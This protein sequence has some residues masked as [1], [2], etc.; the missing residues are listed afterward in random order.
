MNDWFCKDIYG[1]KQVIKKSCC[2]STVA[3]LNDRIE[4][5]SLN[6]SDDWVK[7]A[8]KEKVSWTISGLMGK[9]F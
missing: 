3:S 7:V 9:G 1:L 2:C 5:S 6:S 4:L 8:G